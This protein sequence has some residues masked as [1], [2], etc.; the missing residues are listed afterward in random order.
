MDVVTMVL[1]EKYC[2]PGP[3]VSSMSAMI[4]AMV[5][6]M[7]GGLVSRVIVIPSPVQ[8][9]WCKVTI[10][11][12]TIQLLAVITNTYSLCL[13]LLLVCVVASGSGLELALVTACLTSQC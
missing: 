3:A 10:Y 4:G 8:Q 6:M 7:S 1:K 2:I 12:V 9:Y 5:T 13:G 11:L